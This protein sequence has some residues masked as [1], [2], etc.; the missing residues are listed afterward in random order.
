MAVAALGVAAWLLLP[1]LLGPKTVLELKD[2]PDEAFRAYL[3]QHVD[4][5]DDPLGVATSS[6]PGE[7]YTLTD[8]GVRA[9]LATYYGSAPDDLS[10]LHNA[11][12]ALLYDDA[13]GTWTVRVGTTPVGE[14]AW[15]DNFTSYGTYLAFDLAMLTL[16]GTDAPQLYYYHVVAQQ[17]DA[18]ALGYHMVSLSAAGDLSAS[19][20]DAVAAYDDAT[21]ARTPSFA[22]TWYETIYGMLT[23]N[24][25]ADGT[26]TLDYTAGGQASGTWEQ[27]DATT[28]HVAT[29]ST[30]ITLTYDAATGHLTDDQSRDWAPLT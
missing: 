12:D 4:A 10:Y 26:C 8:D 7:G 21:A 28:I 13:T 27:L 20:P 1:G 30:E 9:I 6:T 24:L 29:T 11:T 18:S 3:Q 23:L 17:S 14:T 2:V 16:P 5:G 25:N 19:F 15:A 22:G